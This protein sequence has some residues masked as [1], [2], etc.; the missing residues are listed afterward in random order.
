[1]KGLADVWIEREKISK[2][3]AAHLI[4]RWP[5]L[6]EERFVRTLISAKYVINN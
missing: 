2:N 5:L 3:K 6:F 4:Q 1:M